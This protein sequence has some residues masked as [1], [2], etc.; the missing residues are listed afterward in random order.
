MYLNTHTHMIHT[1]KS[2][3]QTKRLMGKLD[4]NTM[5]LQVNSFGFKRRAKKEYLHFNR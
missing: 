1:D 3:S 4:E 5:W 2:S